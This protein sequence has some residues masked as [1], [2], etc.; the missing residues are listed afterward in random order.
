MD[1]WQAIDAG[2]TDAARHLLAR[3]CG[4]SRW[5]EAMMARRPFGCRAAL[6]D[7][8]RS[9]WVALDEADWREA[10]A[11]H[12]AIG[13]RASLA[14]RFPAT[15]DLSAREQAGVEAATDAVLDA[16]AEGNRRYEA[17]FGYM[18]IVCA[19]GKTAGEMLELLRRRLNNPPDEEIRIA[20]A[21][22]AEIT[23]LRLG[24]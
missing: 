8:A 15:H 2:T 14:R 4:S 18:F 22:Q 23:A 13:D 11:H 1:T 17:A 9:V 7:A 10:F 3:A 6:L 16:L 19:S 21:E 24:A 5:I 12:P 20:A